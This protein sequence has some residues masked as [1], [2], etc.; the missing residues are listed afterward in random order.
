MWNKLLCGEDVLIIQS[1]NA[2][3]WGKTSMWAQW[4]WSL[5]TSGRFGFQKRLLVSSN[6][7]K[8]DYCWYSRHQHNKNLV[9]KRTHSL[10][11]IK[12]WICT[13]TVY[14]VWMCN[15]SRHELVFKSSL[16]FRLQ[17]I[18]HKYNRVYSICLECSLTF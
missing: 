11:F 7:G 18:G 12:I 1:W 14:A 5:S 15:L 10:K 6:G 16:V 3:V 2:G 4:L 17:Y 13:E 8:C 9:I